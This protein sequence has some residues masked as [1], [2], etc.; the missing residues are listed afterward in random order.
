MGSPTASSAAG[1]GRLAARRRRA[2]CGADHERP[3]PTSALGSMLRLDRLSRS[4]NVSLPFMSREHDGVRRD[5]FTTEAAE[6]AL[7]IRPAN[8]ATSDDLQ[9]VFGTRGAA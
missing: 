8:E 1:P 7:T 9:T 4:Q 3:C 2:P 5:S 6:P